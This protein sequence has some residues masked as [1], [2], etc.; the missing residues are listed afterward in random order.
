MN[1]Q[2]SSS[3]MI[4]YGVA[5][6]TDS[7]PLTASATTKVY[8]SR[9]FYMMAAGTAACPNTFMFSVPPNHAHDLLS[10]VRTNRRL[11]QRLLQVRRQQWIGCEFSSQYDLYGD[12]GAVQSAGNV[13]EHTWMHIIAA[14][15]CH[16]D[17]VYDR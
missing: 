11:C 7:E 4:G 8:T 6:N 9:W 10:H 13:G 16:N 15:T 1:G 14:G 5:T 3:H 12:G 2:A 17:S